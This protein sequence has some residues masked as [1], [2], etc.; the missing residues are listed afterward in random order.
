MTIVRLIF[1]DHTSSLWTFIF[2]MAASF[3]STTSA[4][5]AATMA[6]TNG[7]T[8]SAIV[9]TTTTTATIATTDT[10]GITTSTTVHHGSTS[11]FVFTVSMGILPYT[12]L[13]TT[14]TLFIKGCSLAGLFVLLIQ[15]LSYFT[16]FAGYF[17]LLIMYLLLLT[18]SLI[19]FCALRFG[20][21]VFLIQI[22]I[23]RF[24]LFVIAAC[25][26]SLP[27]FDAVTQL[28]FLMS[29]FPHFFDCCYN[30]PQLQL[31]AH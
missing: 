13:I 18:A 7:A 10:A 30:D 22:L 19:L 20:L 24:L 8:I 9:A 29:K 5:I 14:Y 17:Y 11:S 16:L 3:R 1:G 2:L 27:D 26:C 31:D 12:H 4:T 15:E 25:C 28:F 23:S 21:V 6:S